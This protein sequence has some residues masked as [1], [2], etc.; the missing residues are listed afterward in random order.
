MVHGGQDNVIENNII[1]D[2]LAQQ[3]EYLPI[4][5]LLRGRTPA[6][7]DKSLWLMSGTKVI[8]NI[9]AYHDQTA[10]WAKGRQWDQILATSDRNLIWPGGSSVTIDDTT[11]SDPL[12]WSVWQEGGFDAHSRIADPLFVDPGRNDYRLHEKSP[13]HELGFQPIPFERI[14]LHESPDRAS[15][16]VAH[17]CWREEHIIYPNG[18][19]Q[20]AVRDDLTRQ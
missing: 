2:C 18:E 7:T 4:D 8:R 11:V 15:W 17:D 19:T 3:I 16:P 12:Q 13:A 9:F 1:I 14:G 10:H 20:A 6:H 5:D